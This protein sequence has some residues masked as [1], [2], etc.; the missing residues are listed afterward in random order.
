MIKNSRRKSAQ[1]G[2]TL[3]ELLVVIAIIAILIS[4]LLP[5]VQQAREAARRTQCKN[6]LKQLGLAIHN[7]VDT[8][9]TT[10]TS[11]EHTIDGGTVTEARVFFPVSF[12]TASLPYI[13]QGN[14]Y[15]AWNFSYPY[16][17]DEATYAD[18]T[19]PTLAKTKISTFLCPS[20]GFYSD[21]AGGGYGQTDYMPIAYTNLVDPSDSKT[22][23]AVKGPIADQ[24]YF[25]DGFLSGGPTGVGRFRD[26]TDGL[27]NTIAVIEDAGRPANIVGKYDLPTTHTLQDACGVGKRCPNRWADGDTGH[28]P[29]LSGTGSVM[30][31]GLPSG[32][33]DAAA[34]RIVEARR[35]GDGRRV[36]DAAARR[37]AEARRIVDDSDIS[38][39]ADAAAR[40]V[41]EARRITD[42]PGIEAIVDAAARR[43]AE[44]RRIV[45]DGDEAAQSDAAARRTAEARRIVDDG[46]ETDEAE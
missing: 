21:D 12:F 42:H 20:N 35:V 2:F 43:V 10:P 14:V 31:A 22:S 45:D 4:L 41:A 28:P 1:R 8:Y 23:V 25:A 18:Q 26:C 19:N 44:A 37:M 16:L 32:G 30:F 15:T 9:G 39:I 5:A 13:D 38:A 24:A 33:A 34:R 17:A 27:T 6:N 46:D 7:Y 3:I 36:T 29:L 40:R 11:G